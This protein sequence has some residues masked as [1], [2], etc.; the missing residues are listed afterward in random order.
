MPSFTAREMERQQVEG[1][2]SISE[3]LVCEAKLTLGMLRGQKPQQRMCPEDA[4]Q[5][6]VLGRGG[7]KRER[8]PEPQMC[9]TGQAGLRRS[10]GDGVE[11]SDHICD[12]KASGRKP[13]LT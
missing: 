11:E 1:T 3:Q 10:R 9:F 4:E 5:S 8:F 6:P 13:A 2:C 7:W 12:G